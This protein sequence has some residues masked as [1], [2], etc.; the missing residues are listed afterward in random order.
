MLCG[1][2]GDGMGKDIDDLIYGTTETV[3][4]ER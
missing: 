2:G 3:H 1:E 4:S